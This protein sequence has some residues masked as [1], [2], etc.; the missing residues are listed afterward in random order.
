MV[1]SQMITTPSV[2]VFSAEDKFFVSGLEKAEVG[3][4]VDYLISRN[5]CI[6]TGLVYS[7][8][9]TL[10]DTTVTVSAE[11]ETVRIPLV[12]TIEGIDTLT[13]TIANI[14]DTTTSST[15]LRLM[16]SNCPGVS[17]PFFEDFEGIGVEGDQIPCWPGWWS[18]R[19]SG[20]DSKFAPVAYLASHHPTD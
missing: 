7:L 15:A 6:T 16:V 19:P 4:T 8:H 11:A 3:D 1:R 14:F 20:R 2:T 9:S 17:V 10:L 18:C 5:N 12:Y 13:A